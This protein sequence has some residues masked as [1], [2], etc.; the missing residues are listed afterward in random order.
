[1]RKLTVIEF[2]SLDGI[3]QAPGGPDEDTSGEFKYAN[4]TL[5]P[6]RASEFAIFTI[7]ISDPPMPRLFN[8][9]KMLGS[10]FTHFIHTRTCFAVDL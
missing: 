2:I 10:D 5:V 8:T 4:A 3:I 6:E 7:F 9:N 1:M